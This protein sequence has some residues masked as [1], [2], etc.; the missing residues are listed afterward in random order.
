MIFF[1]TNKFHEACECCQLLYFGR[2]F[3]V[4][5]DLNL[6]KITQYKKF[7]FKNPRNYPHILFGGYDVLYF[8]EEYRGI[9]PFDTD[10]EST[11]QHIWISD[12]PL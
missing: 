1:Y 6:F 4:A 8:L 11:A 7:D 9:R 10:E 2:F 3:E 12:L 5:S